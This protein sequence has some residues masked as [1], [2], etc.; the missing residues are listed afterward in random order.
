MN[1]VTNTTRA[2]SYGKQLRFWGLG[3]V[4]FLALVW[5]LQDV[6]LPFVAGMVLAYF[7]DPLVEKF[8]Q[9]RMRRWVGVVCVLGSFILVFVALIM[10]AVPLIKQQIAD[11]ITAMPGYAKRVQ[12]LVGPLVADITSQVSGEDVERL[13]QAAGNYAGSVLSWIGGVIERIV[14]STAALAN[15]LSVVVITPIVAFYMLRDWPKITAGINNLLPKQHA[16]TIQGILS[17]IDKTM[18][19]FVRGQLTVCFIL[20]VFYAIVLSIAGLNFGFVIGLTSGLLSFIPYIGSGFGLIASVGVAAFQFQDL[21]MVAIIAAIFLGGQLVEG[22]FLTPRLVGGSVGLHDVWIIFALMVGGSLFGFMG[23]LLAVP[24][25]AIIG[26]LIRFFISQYK[27]SSLYNGTDHKPVGEDTLMAAQA[28][29]AE[30]SPGESPAQDTAA[31]A[32]TDPAPGQITGGT[33]T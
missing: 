7:L 21:T 2:P 3:M 25:A 30:T 33:A 23:L 14:T 10:L 4:V 31:D 17:D 24:V 20:G 16:P 19:G 12:E 13:R 27:S 8:D 29:D 22:N 15:I 6:L 5:L 18:A 28:P 11:L 1:A 9:T 32:A 26:V